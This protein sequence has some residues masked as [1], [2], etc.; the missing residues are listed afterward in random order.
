M[1]TIIWVL[2]SFVS[3]AI[4]FSFLLG[5]IFLHTDIRQYGDGNPG[6]FNAWKAGNAKIG[7]PA[8]ILDFLKGAIPVMI[9]NFVVKIN[10]LELV[11]VALAPII[12]HAFSPFLKF[13]GGKA[14]ASTFGIWT[15]LTLW[16]GPTIIGTFL[17][18]SSLFRIADAWSVMISMLGLFIYLAFYYSVSGYD[19]AL[20][21]IW[22]GNLLILAFKHRDDLKKGFKIKN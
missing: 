16:Q 17:G 22:L 15:G 20:F 11:A 10:G 14:V 3:G 13:R 6:A 7:F 2:I 5:K 1:E 18:I 12:G 21:F 19:Q 9:A 4:P 8:L